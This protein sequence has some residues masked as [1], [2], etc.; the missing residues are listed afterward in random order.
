VQAGVY[1]RFEGETVQARETVPEKPELVPKVMVS[2]DDPPGLTLN[3]EGVL[4]VSGRVAFTVIMTLALAVIKPVAA[5][6]ALTVAV[7]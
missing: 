2:V 6:E 1:V 4:G 7:K 5:S 3:T